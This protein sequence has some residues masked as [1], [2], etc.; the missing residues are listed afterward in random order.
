MAYNRDPYACSVAAAGK[1]YVVGGLGSNGK[2]LASVEFYSPGNNSWNTFAQL[3]SARSDVGCAVSGNNIIVAG[4]KD[5]AGAIYPWSMSHSLKSPANNCQTWHLAKSR[6]WSVLPCSMCFL[7][8][9]VYIR[10]RACNAGTNSS[11]Q[12]LAEV[13]AIDAVKGNMTRLADML[14][15]RFDMQLVALPSGD[16]LAVG[17]GQHVN[18][19][20]VQRR[21]PP[22]LPVLFS[23]EITILG[24]IRCSEKVHL[25]HHHEATGGMLIPR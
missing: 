23:R 22:L 11:N 9:E 8:H 2:P 5:H 18:K 6:R 25:P 17:G 12:D 13:Y 15:G 10:A 7:P 24:L 20:E 3:P 4:G 1:F 14:Q 16:A 21:L 19:T